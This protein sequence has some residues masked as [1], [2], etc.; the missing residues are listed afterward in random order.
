MKTRMRLWSMWMNLITLTTASMSIGM[1][2][3]SAAMTMMYKK[4][5]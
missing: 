5:G 1:V 4:Y 2:M 3:R